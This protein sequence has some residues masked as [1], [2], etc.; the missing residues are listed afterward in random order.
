[1]GFDMTEAFKKVKDLEGFN[2]ILEIGAHGGK[3]GHG[4]LTQASVLI[5]KNTSKPKE[6]AFHISK[7]HLGKKTKRFKPSK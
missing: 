4:K 6:I 3:A 7:G 5:Y 2:Y 1:M